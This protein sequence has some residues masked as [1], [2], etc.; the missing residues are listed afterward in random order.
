M[1][2][3]AMLW[4]C[5]KLLSGQKLHQLDHRPFHSLVRWP[6][7]DGKTSRT[8]V[9]ISDWSEIVCFF[10]HESLIFGF[11]EKNRN[12]QPIW[13]Q[14]TMEFPVNETPWTNPLNE[15]RN[16]KPHNLGQA[17]EPGQFLS[18]ICLKIRKPVQP[19]DLCFFHRKWSEDHIIHIIPYIYNISIVL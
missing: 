1:Q 8:E 4:R 6:F 9:A 7:R 14:K 11:R 19:R 10:Q 5:L 17:T 16:P 12:P 15:T 3:K 18:S 13:W 2:K